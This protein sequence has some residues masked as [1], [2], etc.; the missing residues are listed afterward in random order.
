MAELIRLDI[1]DYLTEVNVQMIINIE[2]D[3]LLCCCFTPSIVLG[4]CGWISFECYYITDFSKF[5]SVVSPVFNRFVVPHHLS[6]PH[7]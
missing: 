4:L 1:L 5:A 2:R 7:L 3:L 6:L